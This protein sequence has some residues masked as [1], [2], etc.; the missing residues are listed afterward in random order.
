MPSSPPEAGTLLRKPPAAA[1][2]GKRWARRA[3]WSLALL[4]LAGAWLLYSVLPYAIL[5]PG[6]FERWAVYRGVAP[7]DFGLNADEMRVEAEPGL[8][9]R[10]WHVPATKG[11]T[12]GTVVLLHGSS[13][14]KE[15]MLG[16]AKLFSERGY[17]CLLYDARAHGE[18][19]G[20][21]CTFGF[22][23]RRDFSRFVEEAE[24]RFG[25]L[26]PL[27]VFG[28][29][30]GGAVA[31]QIMA[32]APR[33]CCGIVESPFANLREIVRD[34]M[35]HYSGVRFPFLSN[36][37][38]ARAGQI[39]HFPV[40]AVNPEAAAGN[41][42]QPVLLA[43]GTDDHWIS[44]RHGER[45]AH[46]LSAPGSRWLPVEGADHGG[47]WKAGGAEYRRQVLEF[48]DLHCR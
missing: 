16:L 25:P 18:S 47:I 29:S 41:I 6:R 14:C 3:G 2:S 19:G 28:N 34:Y 15:A 13:S 43:H 44:L 35:G 30:L 1:S 20:T 12:H 23:E 31:L 40:D 32:E 9:L 10:G 48:L 5:R 33:I 42:R 8:W 38:L 21:Y 39:A 45:I 26:G 17:R 7:V 36:L 46:R 4:F 11:P 27:A 22:Y 24:R 37:A